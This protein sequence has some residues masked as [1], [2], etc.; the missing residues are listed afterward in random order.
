[1]TAAAANPYD[2][3]LQK[4]KDLL[5]PTWQLVHLDDKVPTLE[6]I[7][8]SVDIAGMP[9]PGTNLQEFIAGR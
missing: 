3:E 6:R 5:D 1:M 2:L 4:T 7:E 8:P 9:I